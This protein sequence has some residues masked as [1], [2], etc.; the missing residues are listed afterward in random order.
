[1]PSGKLA[2]Q[3]TRGCEAARVLILHAFLAVKP[4]SGRSC[5]LSVPIGDCRPRRYRLIAPGPEQSGPCGLTGEQIPT[6]AG[7]QSTLSPTTA[8]L[9]GAL[10]IAR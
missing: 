1:M 2:L 5:L 8:R 3:V 9:P 10:L 4:P 6:L 7:R